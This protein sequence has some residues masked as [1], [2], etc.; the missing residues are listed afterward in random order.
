MWRICWVGDHR[1]GRV[2]SHGGDAIW[3]ESCIVR[4][5]HPWKN[6]LE[7][8]KMHQAKAGTNCICLNN[9]KKK[10][11]LL[12][13]IR[14]SWEERQEIKLERQL[15]SWSHQALHVWPC[16]V[17]SKAKT[18]LRIEGDVLTNYTSTIDI[19]PGFLRY[20]KIYSYPA[21]MPGVWILFP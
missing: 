18:H 9:R 11:G 5:S 4:R 1:I 10:K 16:D 3:E 2:R 14:V 20:T 17:L 12:I 13:C 21:N 15:G 8:K 7:K 6:I 19:N